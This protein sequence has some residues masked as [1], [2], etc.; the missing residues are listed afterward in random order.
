MRAPSVA[1]ALLAVVLAALAACG[2][3]TQSRPAS[4]PQSAAGEIVLNRG[5]G[6]EPKSL[7]PA[8]IDGIWEGQIAGDMLLGLTTEDASSH[9]IPGAAESWET[10]DDGLTWTFHL[11]D[12]TWSDGVPV[13]AEDFVFAWRRILDPNSAAPYAYYLYPIRNARDVNTGKQPETALGVEARDAKTLVVRLDHPLP[14]MIEFLTHQS[15]YPVPRHAVEAKG[16]EWSRPGNF[17]SNGAY[18]L[19]KWVPNDRVTLVKNPRFYDAANVKIDV[20]N[21]YP[22][23]D[24]DAA[25]RRLRAGEL[26]TQDPIP[27]LQIDFLRANMPDALK[28]TP[29]LTIAYASINLTHKPLDDVRIREAL[30]LAVERETLVERILK[31]GDLPAYNLVPPGTANYPGGVAMRFKNMPFEQRLARAQQLMRAAGYS[32]ERPLRISLSTTTNVVTRQTIAPL[33][34]MWRKI[35]VDLEVIQSDA[36]V[37]YQK[38]EDGDFDLGIAGW[39][40]DYNDPSNFLDVLRTGGGNNYSRYSNP[41]FDALLDDAAA[42]RDLLKRG[43]MLAQAEQMMLDEYPMVFIRFMTQPAIAQPYVKGWIPSSKQLNRTRWLSIER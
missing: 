30:N 28:I 19:T 24:G 40:A 23:P 31:L 22:T 10:S 6:A 15:M 36:Q 41:R 34:E 32:P 37:N 9:P 35:Y 8:V 26:D 17:V 2:D 20:V 5:N 33:Q 38:L 3:G 11:R 43:E 7:D 1:L 18:V 12:H 25:L 39:I 13:T 4:G 29:T 42:E 16:A 27:P 21:Y 14:F